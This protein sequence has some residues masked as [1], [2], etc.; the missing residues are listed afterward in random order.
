MVPIEA[1]SFI[2]DV[3]NRDYFL[4][5]RG[6]FK[7]FMKEIPDIKDAVYQFLQDNNFLNDD[8][9]AADSDAD[10]AG[11]LRYSTRFNNPV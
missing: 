8:G 1:S 4:D 7:S 6:S 11:N 9:E 10:E 3:I 5:L 2:Y